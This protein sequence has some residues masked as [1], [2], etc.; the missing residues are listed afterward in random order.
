M[1]VTRVRQLVFDSLRAP[2]L[3]MTTLATLQMYVCLCEASISVRVSPTADLE[4]CRMVVHGFVWGVYSGVHVIERVCWTN[5]AK[6]K[7]F[8]RQFVDYFSEKLQAEV[9]VISAK[10]SGQV[11]Q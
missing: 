1:L 2:H 10:C 5:G 7:A 6:E 9:S 3:V 4:D 11:Q 8:K